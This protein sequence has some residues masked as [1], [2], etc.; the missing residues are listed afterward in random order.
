MAK[1]VLRKASPNLLGVLISAA[2]GL[3]FLALYRHWLMIEMG[4]I[5]FAADVLWEMH[6]ISRDWWKYRAS[7]TYNIMGRLPIEIP[8]TFFFLGVWAVG[9]VLLTL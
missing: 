4:V 5:A 1:E 3:L 8:L 6:G 9:I 7:P 2:I